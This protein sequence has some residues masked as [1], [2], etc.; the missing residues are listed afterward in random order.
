MCQYMPILCNH[1]KH[2]TFLHCRQHENIILK[3]Q[4]SC[5]LFYKSKTKFYSCPCTVWLWGGSKVWT[6]FITLIIS[7]NNWV[8]R[9][10]ITMR[11]TYYTI[12]PVCTIFVW[13]SP[14]FVWLRRMNNTSGYFRSPIPEGSRKNKQFSKLKLY[15]INL[16]HHIYYGLE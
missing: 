7:L 8:F 9:N 11:S 1:G 2:E 14:I 4:I 15:H 13:G 5:I 16:R 10:L 6:I 3:K 12:I